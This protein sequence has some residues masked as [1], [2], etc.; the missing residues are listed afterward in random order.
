MKM[1]QREFLDQSD[2]ELNSSRG[3]TRPKDTSTKR[4]LVYLPSCARPITYMRLHK[5]TSVN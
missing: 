4:S 5:Y 3:N 2:R 1:R